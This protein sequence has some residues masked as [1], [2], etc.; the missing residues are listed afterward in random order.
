MAIKK[1]SK[2]EK[3]LCAKLDNQS[4]CWK[5]TITGSFNSRRKLSP[6]TNKTT[7]LN[8]IKLLTTKPLCCK[9]PYF[10]N[11]AYFYIKK[12]LQNVIMFQNLTRLK[13]I[14]WRALKFSIQF[15][16][17]VCLMGFHWMIVSV[18]MIENNLLHGTEQKRH[19]S[20]FA[21]NVWEMLVT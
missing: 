3:Y 14:F 20:G 15:R 17:L 11:Q 2:K 16:N 19:F 1:I 12:Y 7:P 8:P 10:T 9:V 21:R 13:V 4:R 6:E 18:P 5:P